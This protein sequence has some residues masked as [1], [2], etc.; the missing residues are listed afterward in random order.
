MATYESDC[1]EQRVKRMFLLAAAIFIAASYVSYWWVSRVN[2]LIS[3]HTA[4]LAADGDMHDVASIWL[5]SGSRIDETSVS[6]MGYPIETFVRNNV[7]VVGVQSPV[8][9]GTR[10]LVL[11]Y[12]GKSASL[13]V[14]FLPS[15]RDSFGDGTPD[16][17]RF[18]VER[19]R[20]AFRQWFT[21]LADTTASLPP[22][23]LPPEINDCAALLRWC[24]RNALHAHND[25][26]VAT[27]PFE[28]LPPLPSIRQYDYPSTPLG[29]GI[30]RVRE[31]TYHFGDEKN[32]SFAEFADA[33]TL[34]QRNTYFVSRDVR[35]ARP[36]DLLFYCQLEQNS[37]YHSMILTGQAHNWAVYDTGPIGNGPGE[38]RRVALEDLLH[39]P[40]ARWRPIP[41]NSN[42][43]GVYRWSILREDAR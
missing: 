32:G 38:I 26:W 40:D 41:Q 12:R 33:K 4:N 37:P 43:L 25:A 7:T 10:K 8:N 18:H 14:N 39:H 17:L 9:P 22:Q 24:Y 28:S 31:G 3:T 21:T 36:G 16:F 29:A 2:L 5:S 11:R 15:D 13:L 27:M 23:H 34:W 30:F 35:Y 6:S 20:T 42:F 19:D 1:V